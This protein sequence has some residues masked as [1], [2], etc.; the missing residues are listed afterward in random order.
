M[1]NSNLATLPAG[2]G[3]FSLAPKDLEE[4]MR[5][6]D[7]LSKSS[8]VPKDYQGNPGNVIVAVQ[9]GAE[10]GLPPLQAMQS[11]AVINGRPSIWGDAMLALVR[12]SGL[13]EYIRE[14]ITED[15]ATCTLKR[16]GEDEVVRI[17]TKE[18]AKVAGLLGKQGPWQTAPKRMMQMRARAFALRDVFTDVLRGVY[19]AEEAQDLPAERDITNES[20]QV[21]EAP[22]SRAESV[23]AALSDRR[24]DAVSVPPMHIPAVGEV[25]AAINR[26]S[27]P[28]AMKAASE[29]AKALNDA[30]DK[31]AASNAYK[32]RIA[33]L[34]RQSAT[35]DQE[36]GEIED[37][38][39]GF[40][41]TYAEVA[42][43]LEKAKTRDDLDVACDLIQH[44][45][46]LPQREELGGIVKRRLAE[47]KE[48]DK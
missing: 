18:D 15:G 5:F 43:Q 36:T 1:S 13:L 46:D 21:K 2:K 32:A 4:A 39:T 26:A 41:M 31:Q 42:A 9:W 27:T 23:K 20:E 17:F 8:V 24:K 33:E 47:F 22:K 38:A 28:E 29:L 6:A 48:G 10:I 12:A 35:V 37:A 30:D 11:I 45:A 19:V 44:V 34:K 14:D 40:A 3:N 16:R 7:L 25:L